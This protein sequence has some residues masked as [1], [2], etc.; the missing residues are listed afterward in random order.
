MAG[1]SAMRLRCA[2]LEFSMADKFIDY[3]FSGRILFGRGAF[4]F[5]GVIVAAMLR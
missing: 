4:F 2:A 1:L 3:W 5:Y